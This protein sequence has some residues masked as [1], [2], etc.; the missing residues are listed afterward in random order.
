M[1][2]LTAILLSL[3]FTAAAFAAEPEN[4]PYDFG[5]MPLPAFNYTPETGFAYGVAA[6]YA[7]SARS[8]SLTAKTDT[9]I[10]SIVYTQKKQLCADLNIEKYFDN[11]GL[12]LSVHPKFNYYPSFTWGLGPDSPGSASEGF[13]YTETDAANSFL[14][15]LTPDIKLGVYYRFN[16][17]GTSGLTSGGLLDTGAVPGGDGAVLSA[18]GARFVYDTRDKRFSP[19]S[20]Y[21]VDVMAAASLKAL[22]SSNDFYLFE[23]EAK[24]FYTLFPDN[25]LC[26]DAILRLTGKG[27]PF[28]YIPRLGGM[29]YMRGYY[30]GRYVDYAYTALEAEYRFPIFWT[31]RGAV[32]GTVGQ[33]AQDIMSFK[34]EGIKG[35]WG[36][37]IHWTPFDFMDSPLRFDLAFAH[38]EMNLYIDLVEAF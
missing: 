38:G 2:K 34:T 8:L 37:G 12:Y 17:Y 6:L 18:L 31:F 28:R 16:A 33:V 5:I 25:Y 35:A 19:K 30:E 21:V 13:T 3:L 4:D 9:G 22:G 20:G 24:A 29:Y 7:G 14:K 10:F 26:L 32:F 11:G 1:Q 36:F 23:S 27:A 15:F